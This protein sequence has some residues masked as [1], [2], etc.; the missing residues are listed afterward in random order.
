M[1]LPAGLCDGCRFG[2]PIRSRRG[3]QFWLC[4]RH[5]TDDRFRKYPALPVLD[6]PGYEPSRSQ[7]G[8]D[9]EE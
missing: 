4:A 3:S 8:E 9:D 6:C 7:G 1:T 2:R 5:T